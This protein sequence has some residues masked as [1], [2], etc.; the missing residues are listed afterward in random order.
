MNGGKT[1][2]WAVIGLGRFG[3]IHAEV[4]AQLPGVELVAVCRRDPARLAKATARWSGV[5]GSTDYREL[6]ARP[7]IDAVTIATHWREH[8]AVARDAL[9]AGK[10]VLLEKPMAETSAQCRELV[11]LAAA[12]TNFLMVGHVCRFDPR[13]VQAREAVLAGRI[14]RIISLHAKR[15]LPLAPGPLR[16]DKISPLMGDGVHDADLMLWLLGSA[17]TRVYAR[18]VRVEQFEHPDLAWALL[19]FGETAV[20]VIET[21]WRLPPQVPTA[22]DAVLEVVGTE[23]L[24]R[25]D[26][27]HAG[28]EILD[29]RGSQFPDTAYWPLVHGQRRGALASEIQYFADCVRQQRPPEVISP[30]EAAAAVAVM[31]AAERSAL[32][33]QPVDFAS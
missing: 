2:R 33:G 18:T 10:H 4:L 22:I 12:Q 31:E 15:N 9:L 19:E 14:G 27:G 32:I 13:V 30:R 20:G 25:I 21:N 11:E 6:L 1:V 26:C 24:L 23:G 7:D 3:T 16:L 17:P 29:A 5:A 8:F 28:L